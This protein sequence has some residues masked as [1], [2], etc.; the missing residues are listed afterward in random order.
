MLW[1]KLFLFG[2]QNTS[3]HVLL[4][5]KV[6]VEKSAVI[7]LGLPLCVICFFSVLC[8]YC[9]NYNMLWGSSILVKSVWC[10][11]GFLHL[12]GQNFPEIWEIFCYYFIGYLACTSFSSMPVILRFD[13]LIEWLGS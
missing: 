11:G 5:F 7:L 1:L 4:A 8:V 3:L 10:S 9:F 13:L 2:A 6:S 12:N